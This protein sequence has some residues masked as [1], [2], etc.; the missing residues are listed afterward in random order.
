MASD[1]LMV[2]TLFS[3]LTSI[4]S[5]WEGEEEKIRMDLNASTFS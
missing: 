4:L 1:G 2:L 5:L 3:A